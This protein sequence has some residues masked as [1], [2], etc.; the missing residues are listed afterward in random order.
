MVAL[1][2]A[3]SGLNHRHSA[4]GHRGAQAR[5]EKSDTDRSGKVRLPRWRGEAGTQRLVKLLP[6]TGVGVA[7][8]RV[9]D[10]SLAG[11]GGAVL[12]GQ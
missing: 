12:Q 11:W 7:P 9:Q 1:Q 6:W 2:E 10:R 3:G 5:Q 8:G 4:G